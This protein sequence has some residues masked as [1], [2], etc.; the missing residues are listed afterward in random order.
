MDPC[1]ERENLNVGTLQA[2][3]R[4]G[5]TKLAQNQHINAAVLRE[6][7]PTV[8]FLEGRRGKRK[9]GV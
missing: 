4:E 3:S 7:N 1:R 9:A 6:P 8:S 2:R 5:M